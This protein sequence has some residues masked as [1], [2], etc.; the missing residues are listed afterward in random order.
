M[1]RLH[2]SKCVWRHPFPL[3]F[4]KSRQLKLVGIWGLGECISYEVG[5]HPANHCFSFAS[6]LAS[7]SLPSLSSLYR[8]LISPLRIEESRHDLEW[9]LV[10]GHW[11][12]LRTVILCPWGLRLLV[13][14]SL[15]QNCSHGQQVEGLL[16]SRLAIIFIIRV[17]PLS[18]SFKLLHSVI[19]T[20]YYWTFWFSSLVNK[21]VQIVWDEPFFSYY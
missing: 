9:I 16:S 3:Y 1:G 4:S 21:Q 17:L 8:L 19:E 2:N 18:S 7:T 6:V 14:E 10:G 13:G 11:I 15:V 12:R 5:S 20:V